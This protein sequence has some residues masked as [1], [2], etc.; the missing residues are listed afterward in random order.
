MYP[1]YETT[2]PDKW[3]KKLKLTPIPVKEHGGH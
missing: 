2:T 1:F 3:K